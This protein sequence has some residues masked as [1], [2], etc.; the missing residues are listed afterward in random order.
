MPADELPGKMEVLEEGVAFQ[1][2]AIR[3]LDEALANQQ[4][5]LLDISR[6]LELVVEQVREIELALR[7]PTED[8]RPPHH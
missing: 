3:K 7:A 4:R 5:Q 6:Q 1:E 2:D 8:E